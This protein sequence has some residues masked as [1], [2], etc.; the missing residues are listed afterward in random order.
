MLAV[1]TSKQWNGRGLNGDRSNICAPLWNR[2]WDAGYVPNDEYVRSYSTEYFLANPNYF[3]RSHYP[4]A[5]GWLLL[6]TFITLEDF[7]SI[8]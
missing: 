5:P 4:E 2:N 1:G 6:D 8:K 3:V 7:K